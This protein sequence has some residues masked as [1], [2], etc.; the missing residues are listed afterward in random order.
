MPLLAITVLCAAAVLG[1][2][3]I[4][5]EIVSGQTSTKAKSSISRADNPGGFWL[6]IMIKAAF[7]VFAVAVLLHAL[8]LTGDPIVWL[9]ETFPAFVRR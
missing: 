5:G 7:V 4:V 2:W 1:A 6:T 8:G 9:R 3:F